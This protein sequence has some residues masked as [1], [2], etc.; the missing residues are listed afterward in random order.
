MRPAERPAAP[1]D[2]R[3]RL[4]VDL[5]KRP[6]LPAPL[7]GRPAEGRRADPV[8]REV[9]R[10]DVPAA[11]ETLRAAVGGQASALEDRDLERRRGQLAGDRDAGRPR[12][13]D[14][15]VRLE[16]AVRG[17]D[18]R[19]TEHGRRRAGIRRAGG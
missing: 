7:V 3:P 17:D 14:A 13:D 12:A 10:A 5:V 15:D 4:E 16:D 8:E 6:A 9:G 19:V 1:G 18:P 11:Q 2:L